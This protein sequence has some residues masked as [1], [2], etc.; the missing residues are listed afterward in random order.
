MEF[1]KQKDTN[2]EPSNRGLVKYV[3]TVCNEK[4]CHWSCGMGE[5]LMAQKYA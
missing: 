3:S 1:L 4:S 2:L 5:Y